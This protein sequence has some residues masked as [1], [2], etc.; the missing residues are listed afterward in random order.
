MNLPNA[1]QLIRLARKRQAVN[2]FLMARAENAE[3]CRKT[4]PFVLPANLA[5]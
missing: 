1:T 5:R 3:K 2:N 4:F